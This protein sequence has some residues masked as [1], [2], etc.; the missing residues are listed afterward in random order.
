MIVSVLTYSVG[1]QTTKLAL[2]GITATSFVIE[3]WWI[4]IVYNRFPALQIGEERKR[5]RRGSSGQDEQQQAQSN[6]PL[7]GHPSASSSPH[8]AQECSNLFQREWSTW[9][10]FAA[11]PIFWS[12]RRPIG[13]G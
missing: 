8:Q 2:I 12:E 1:Y 11:L 7:L 6:E 5:R 4:Q 10:E 13:C 3:F 9:R